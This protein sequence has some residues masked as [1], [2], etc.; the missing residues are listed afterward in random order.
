M[1]GQDICPAGIPVVS[2]IIPTRVGTRSRCLIIVLNKSG[3]SPRVWGQ[4]YYVWKFHLHIGIIPT[5]VGT[6]TYPFCYLKVHKDHPHACGDKCYDATAVSVSQR[7]IPTRVGTRLFS[8]AREVPSRDH[9][10][11]CGDKR[12][13][14]QPAS[15][16]AGSSPRVWGQA[17]KSMSAGNI[18]RIIP[19]RVGTS[20]FKK[21]CNLG[22]Q[23]HPHACGDKDDHTS[24]AAVPL[25]SSPRVWG[26]DNT[27]TANTIFGRIIPTH[28]GT[29]Q[30]C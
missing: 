1:W 14:C 6:S 29:R 30:V 4:V 18:S 28:V 9:P 25:G 20:G 8:C 19:T 10:H 22:T 2:G 17:S 15:R 5:R 13:T 21:P 3:S 26:Q 7:I 12:R 24:T 11:A 16:N 23:D 27:W